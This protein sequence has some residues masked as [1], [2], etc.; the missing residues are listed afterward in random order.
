MNRMIMEC[1]VLD[2]ARK[3]NPLTGLAYRVVGRCE[4]MSVHDHASFLMRW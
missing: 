1:V 2:L 3:G 4:R